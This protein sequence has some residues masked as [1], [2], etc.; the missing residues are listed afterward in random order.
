M[1]SYRHNFHAGNFADVLKHIIQ[2]LILNALSQKPKPYVYFDTHAGAGRYDLTNVKSL[3]ISEHKYGID[4]ILSLKETP[5]SIKTYLDAVKSINK[6]HTMLKYYPGSPLLAQL[7]MSTSNRLEL[8]ELHPTDFNLLKQEFVHVRNACIEKIDGYKNLV[9]KLP[10]IQRRALVLIDPPYELKTEYQD[11]FNAIKLAHKKFA[12]GIYALWYPVV[13]RE[14]IETFVL[15]FKKS[16]LKDILRVEM[17]VKKEDD[18]YGMTGTGMLIIN[19]P[20]KIKS[21]LT[22]LLPWLL[23]QLKQ[24]DN[25]NFIIEQLVA[26]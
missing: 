5:D 7:I 25:A 19:P 6:D 21:Q 20:W 13:S 2:C 10:P 22:D 12:T 26:E 14:K 24:D 8:S 1:L 18:N 16:G 3:K 9:S 11:A 23:Q 17:N 15:K 4:K